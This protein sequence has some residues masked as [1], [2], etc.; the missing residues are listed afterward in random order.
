MLLRLTNLLLFLV[1]ASLPFEWANIELAGI[2]WTPSKVLNGM[3]LALALVR[4]A[5]EPRRR[6]QDPKLVWFMLFGFAI[7][8][9]TRSGTGVGPGES[10][11]YFMANL[12]PSKAMAHGVM[13]TRGGRRQPQ[14]LPSTYIDE[15]PV[16]P[17][18]RAQHRSAT[19]N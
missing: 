16:R 8:V 9:S 19:C 2:N 14:D 18:R 10:R 15:G 7:A 6:R 17:V 4:V 1:G 5:L 3:L 11:R 13:A 12:G